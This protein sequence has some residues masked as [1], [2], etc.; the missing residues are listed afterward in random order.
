MYA[1]ARAARSHS[2]RRHANCH[3]KSARTPLAAY[4]SA[5]RALAGTRVRAA[6]REVASAP[7]ARG[8][9][10]ERRRGAGGGAANGDGA[11]K[12]GGG[13]SG[14]AAKGGGAA[15]GGGALGGGALGGGALGGGA[16][17]G[18]ALGG[19]APAAAR[20]A[21]ARSAAARSAPP[22]SAARSAAPRRR[23]RGAARRPAVRLPLLVFDARISL[24]GRGPTHRS[25]GG[26]AGGRA[27]ARAA[28]T[29][30]CR[31]PVV[32]A[33]MGDEARPSKQPEIGK[34]A[35]IEISSHC[36]LILYVSPPHE[37]RPG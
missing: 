5:T 24:A 30:R 22:H 11:A 6:R 20:S 36:H 2:T 8:G 12:G 4:T 37:D 26:R 23:P 21:A 29:A 17:G 18:G 1:A 13:S 16:P 10:R 15:A 3:S 31:D 14:G 33:L 7:P 9:R 27:F 19:G 25:F 34:Q 32:D 35:R 28:R